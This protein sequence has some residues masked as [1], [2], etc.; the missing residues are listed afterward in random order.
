MDIIPA[1]CS[2]SHGWVHFPHEHL[3]ISQTE[4]NQMKILP[5][6]GNREN[7]GFDITVARAAN[8]IQMFKNSTPLDYFH[9]I[10]GF[11][12]CFKAEVCD[13]CSTSVIEWN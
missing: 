4:S 10:W 12:Y 8:Q 13:F 11:A 9:L 2:H 7:E 6:K 5:F 1:L 3:F